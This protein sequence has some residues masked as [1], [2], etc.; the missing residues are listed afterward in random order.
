MDPTIAG[1]PDEHRA[2][3]SL[4][5]EV[6]RSVLDVLL[7]AKTPMTPE[8]LANGLGRLQR[9]GS[10]VFRNRE[11]VA[12]GGAIMVWPDQAQPDTFAFDLPEG[13]SAPERP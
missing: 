8:D 11:R 7:S 3:V 10:S 5:C 6:V 2:S 9:S 4:N 12:G 1:Q 13:W